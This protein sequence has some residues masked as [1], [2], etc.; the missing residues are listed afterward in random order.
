MAARL[1]RPARDWLATRGLLFP[2]LALN[3]Q[4]RRRVVTRASDVCLEG[5]PRSANSYSVFAFRHWNPDARIAHH[6]HTP[7]QVARAARLGVPC[8]VLIRPPLDAVV[9][10]LVMDRERISDTAAYRSYIHFYSRAL[11]L[12]EAVVVAPFAE[13]VSEPATV[14]ERL[15]GAFGTSFACELGSGEPARGFL[16][17]DERLSRRQGL[18]PTSSRAPSAAKERRKAELRERLARHPLLAEAQS[19]HAAWLGSR[20]AHS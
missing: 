2:L 20:G 6:L 15:N 14:V 19:L 11:P 8:A 12:R 1:T 3:G 7:L 5:Y 16:A 18:P 17:Q 10:V 4:V 13:V 9:S